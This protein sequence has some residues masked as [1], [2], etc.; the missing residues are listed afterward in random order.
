MIQE[1]SSAYLSTP[2]GHADGRVR[3]FE[4]IKSPVMFVSGEARGP[5]EVAN[6]NMATRTPL[7]QR[8]TVVRCIVHAANRFPVAAR[9]SSCWSIVH[10]SG[11][12][13]LVMLPCSC[14]PCGG[15][16]QDE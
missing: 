14:S 13:M 2:F 11:L 8:C 7:E 6:T 1:Q 4:E 9:N 15:V 5:S 12:A 16:E 10:R 3:Q